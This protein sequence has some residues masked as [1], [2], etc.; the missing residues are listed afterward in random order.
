VRERINPDTKEYR[1]LNEISN[2]EQVRQVR[3]ILNDTLVCRGTD[4]NHQFVSSVM[5]KFFEQ[6]FREEYHETRK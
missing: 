5:D 3:E 4:P 6:G 2:N 1:N